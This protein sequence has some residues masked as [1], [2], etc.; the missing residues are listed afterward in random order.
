MLKRK[1]RKVGSSL[2]IT[3]PSQIA[4]VNDYAE[5]MELFIEIRPDTLIYR[6]NRQA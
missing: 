3:I 1:I 4:V 6:K 2:V 5:G